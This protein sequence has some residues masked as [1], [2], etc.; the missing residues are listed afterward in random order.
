MGERN[1]SA[2]QARKAYAGALAVATQQEK[3]GR[4]S[5]SDTWIVEEITRRLKRVESSD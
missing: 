1:H 5:P 3:M 4:L 2:A